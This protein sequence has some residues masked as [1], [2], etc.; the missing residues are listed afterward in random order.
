[1]N[2]S[3]AHIISD[4]VEREPDPVDSE[5]EKDASLSTTLLHGLSILDC[6]KQSGNQLSNR[7]IAMSNAEIS[8]QLGMNKATV[9]RLCKT[10]MSQ[11]YLQ[12]NSAGKFLLAPRILALSYPILSSMSWRQRAGELM[13][14]LATF[15]QG[16]VSLSVFSGA[17]TV[18]IKTSGGLTNYPHVPEI[19]MT[20]P[21]PETSSGRA[22]LALL[23]PDELDQKLAEIKQA[24][25]E[26]LA[27]HAS[28]ISDSIAS[29]QTRGFCVAFGDWRANI[30]AAS[31]PVG[32]TKDG[33]CVSLTCGVPSYRS[34]RDEIETD[35]GPRIA[36][37]A[38]NLRQMN[39]LDT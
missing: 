16:N 38:E 14:G 18:F 25:P 37:V 2:D 28:K 19:G 27:R 20:T 24:Y 30:F 6:F 12:K 31:A 1:M 26:A 21:L 10:L 34:H 11:N 8:Q 39:I 15:A 3:I 23:T 13:D 7:K 36:L 17:E 35:L 4:W 22:L 9:S 33:I 5:E 29:C 32:R